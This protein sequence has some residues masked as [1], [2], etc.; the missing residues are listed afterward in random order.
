MQLARAGVYVTDPG[1]DARICQINGGAGVL[2]IVKSY[3][4]D[5]MSFLIRA[6]ADMPQGK[7]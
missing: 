4:G 6:M 2:Y 1:P 7:A 5:V 3:A